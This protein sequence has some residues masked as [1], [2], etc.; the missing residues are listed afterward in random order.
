MDDPLDNVFIEFLP[1]GCAWGWSC[2]LLAHSAQTACAAWNC[3][4]CIPAKVN[5]RKKAVRTSLLQ[6]TFNSSY[7][8]GTSCYAYKICLF[9]LTD[10][11]ICAV[12]NCPCC[13]PAK[14]NNRKKAVRTSL[15][16]LTFNSSYGY[17]TSCY[18]YK[19]CLLVC[20]NGRQ[21]GTK[22]LI[23]TA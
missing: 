13:I 22:I 19:I 1:R 10:G 11:R 21:A 4:C 8:Y 17:G 18:A 7:G 14:V 20:F 12:W 16:Q 23:C 2:D 15:L 6:L 3:R 5:N 9:V